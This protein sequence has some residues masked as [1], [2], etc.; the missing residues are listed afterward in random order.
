MIVLDI[1]QMYLNKSEPGGD[2]API[3]ISMQERQGD[4]NAGKLMYKCEI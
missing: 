1:L 3:K 2:H 4:K